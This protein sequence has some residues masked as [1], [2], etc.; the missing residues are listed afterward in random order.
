MR[1]YGVFLSALL[2]T[3][4]QQHHHLVALLMGKAYEKYKCF[5]V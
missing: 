3:V 5:Q 4:T 2:Q 1:G